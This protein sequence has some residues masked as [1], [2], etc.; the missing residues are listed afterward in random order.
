M[1]RCTTA[2][3]LVTLCGLSCQAWHTEGVTPQLLATRAPAT[4]RVTRVDGSQL[5]IGRPALRGDTLF[6]V[7]DRR[8]IHIQ[9]TEV[10]E[11]AT[12][13]F[14]AGR[15]AGLVAGV[16]AVVLTTYLVA[17]AIALSYNR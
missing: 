5:V 8:P 6:G 15:T 17:L 13:R 11:T 10:R 3:L 9:L 2:L 12:R 14:S 7:V 4:L 16:G 1:V